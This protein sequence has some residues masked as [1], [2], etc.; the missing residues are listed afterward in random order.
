MVYAIG[1]AMV[2]FL[3]A[4]AYA[5]CRLAGQCDEAEQAAARR[6]DVR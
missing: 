5:A 1:A 4:I 3:F 2:G 6:R